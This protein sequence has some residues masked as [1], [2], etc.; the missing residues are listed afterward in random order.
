MHVNV[1][2]ETPGSLKYKTKTPSTSFSTIFQ[3]VLRSLVDTPNDPWLYT[4]NLKTKETSFG[5]TVNVIQ[6]LLIELT[7]AKNVTHIIQYVFQRV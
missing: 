6:W 1:L 7:N 2:N 4:Y 5:F 3:I